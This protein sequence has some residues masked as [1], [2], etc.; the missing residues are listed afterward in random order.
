MEMSPEVGELF[1]A[2]AKAQGELGKLVASHTGKIKGQAKG[3]GK[4]YEYSYTYANLADALEAIR[5]PFASNGLFVFQDAFTGEGN[6]VSTRT[7]IGH[8]SG[9]WI[10][11]DALFMPVD[12]GAQAV[13]GAVTYARRYQ[14]LPAVGLAPEDD[15]GA[16]AQAADPGDW[17]RGGTPAGDRPPRQGGPSLCVG[18]YEDIATDID[19]IVRAM[20]VAHDATLDDVFAGFLAGAGIDLS[21]YEP[22]PEGPRALTVKDGIAVR[23]HARTIRATP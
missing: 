22:P 21:R 17:G 19:Q 18:K 2:L 23:K 13:G 8:N 16:E 4:D 14:L 5:E 3:S 11:T 9:Q 12:R 15:D 6:G 1:A 10:C 7:M 20:S